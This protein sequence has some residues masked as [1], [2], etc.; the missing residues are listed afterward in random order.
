[1]AE[2]RKEMDS[3]LSGGDKVKLNCANSSQIREAISKCNFFD[4]SN[5]KTSIKRRHSAIS[6]QGFEI[7]L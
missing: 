2:Q 6:P 7:D 3:F 5:E 1:M 4:D